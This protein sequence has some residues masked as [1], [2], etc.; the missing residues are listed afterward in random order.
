[1]ARPWFALDCLFPLLRGSPAVTQQ[2]AARA[3]WLLV[4][5]LHLVG[6]AGVQTGVT[7]L[8]PPAPVSTAATTPPAP[9]V[10]AVQAPP[11]VPPAMPTADPPHVAYDGKL[12]KV[13]FAPAF[14]A[15]WPRRDQLLALIDKDL[16]FLAARTR[17]TEFDFRGMKIPKSA[18][19][20]ALRCGRQAVVQA[21]SPRELSDGFSQCFE[22]HR[23]GTKE[24][25]DRITAYY[26]H[27]AKGCLKPSKDCSY[28][29]YRRPP[30][31]VRASH[32]IRVDY[33]R[34]RVSCDK[35]DSV[36]PRVRFL[37]SLRRCKAWNKKPVGKPPSVWARIPVREYWQ[38]RYVKTSKGRRLVPYY[39]RSQIDHGAL[40]KHKNLPFAYV[41]PRDAFLAQ[42]EGAIWVSMPDGSVI[43]LTA[44]GQNG[45][46]FSGY[47][48]QLIK[49]ARSKKL[50]VNEY[51]KSIPVPKMM[52]HFWND[53]S[54]VFWEA[55]ESNTAAGT[56]ATPERTVASDPKH[57][58]GVVA[59]LQANGSGVA[60]GHLAL[61]EDVG[62][63]IRTN[64]EELGPAKP[65]RD[66]ID[67]Y[68]GEGEEA[69]KRAASIM[70]QGEVSYLLP[71]PRF[72][73]EPAQVAQAPAAPA[74]VPS[75]PISVA[76]RADP[77]LVSRVQSAGLPN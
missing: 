6:C 29:L 26:T 48:P 11:A 9:V 41:H 68:V 77:S 54:Y 47:A 51:L 45:H 55:N 35:V 7:L 30:D 27:V 10:A 56:V 63:S 4:L 73:A 76:N 32:P 64:E 1:M 69:E 50:K 12:H 52:R 38:G 20:Q 15:E 34:E 33:K 70:A 23:L 59:F 67:W 21:T 72:M 71:H 43:K 39:T 62:G 3:G 5:S 16:A 57:P 25:R 17:F 53:R 42:I 40:K 22:M 36:G 31:L 2:R 58:K 61:V 49:E 75:E 74:K 44:A 66:R 18:Y 65:F 24:E 8:K 28:P 46:P 13:P 37:G 19:E 14:Q 60:L